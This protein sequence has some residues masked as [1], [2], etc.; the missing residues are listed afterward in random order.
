M[1]PHTNIGIIG[2]ALNVGRSTLTSAIVN[3]LAEQTKPGAVIT[4]DEI[5]M[6][7]LEDVK[8]YEEAPKPKLPMKSIFPFIATSA[9][10]GGAFNFPGPSSYDIRH[11]PTREKTPEDLAKIDAARIKRERKANRKKS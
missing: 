2:G 1:R 6:P 7:K 8:M 10:L 3:T 4:A 9:M 11:D 5:K